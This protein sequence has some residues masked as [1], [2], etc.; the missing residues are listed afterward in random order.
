MTQEIDAATA[1]K[2]AASRAR[3]QRERDLKREKGLVCV[4]CWIKPV[5]RK[6]LKE[7][8]RKLQ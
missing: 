6:V 5:N 2:R 8:E 3:K 7:I 1:F 4:Q